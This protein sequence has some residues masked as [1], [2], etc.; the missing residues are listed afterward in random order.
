MLRP[1]WT[2]PASVDLRLARE[3]AAAVGVAPPI[4]ELLVRR[5]HDSVE[6]ARRF[7]DPSFDTLHDPFLMRDMDVAVDRIERA[8]DAA[9][10]IVVYGDYDV[11]GI[12]ATALMVRYLR[13][14][15][16]EVD[17]YIPHRIEEGYGLSM[18]G[19]RGVAGRGASL[20]VTCDCGITAVDEVAEA[21]AAGLDVIVTDHH[22]P[23][24]RIPP[25][26]AVLNPKRED[27]GYPDRNLAAVGV[28]F[29]LCEALEIGAGRSR[30]TIL[31][32]LDLVALGTVADLVPMTGENRVLVRRGL[33][34]LSKTNNAGIQALL[35]R[36]E[37]AGKPIS[38]WQIGFVLAPRINAIGRMDSAERGVELLL[39]DDASEAER[40]ASR[41][42]EV[43]TDRQQADRR[44]LAEA[45]ELVDR[46]YDPDRHRAIVLAGHDWHPGVIGIVASRVVERFHRPTIMISLD[47]DG[48]G[49]GSARSVSGFHLLE[50][51]TA[52]RSHLD[53][54]G[55]HRY[56]AGLAIR[57][58]AVDPFR[59]AFQ[60]YARERLSDEQLVPSL[61]VDL[62]V[63]LQAI[64]G[65]FYSSLCRFAPYGPGNP[66]PVLAMEGLS[67]RG[68]PRIVGEDHL[69]MTV[70]AG[71]CTLDAIGFN[72]GH[73]LQEVDVNRGGLSIACRLRENHYLGRA[74]LQARLI[75]VRTDGQPA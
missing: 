9:E 34:R 31:G 6:R 8:I 16:A 25:G 50:A 35:D 12:T 71:G 3:L 43:N 21:N 69:K 48:R 54:Y 49:R 22:E 70:A 60:A 63:P 15:G 53:A 27:A 67:P 26:V 4:G 11:D 68:Y 13:W 10:P 2:R 66:E 20:V 32:G 36:T 59:E 38:A 44:L 30:E 7:L 52:C 23:G 72:L 18:E 24:E 75:D 61:T 64:D 29:K 45:L 57:R 39:T 5:G 17:F 37:L 74:T 28:A 33:E 58:E 73:L 65:E 46:S 56:A 14:R 41:F 40:I 62:Q 55:G 42:E 51:L 47:E 19:V 1:T